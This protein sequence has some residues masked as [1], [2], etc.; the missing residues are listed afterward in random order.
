MSFEHVVVLQL[1]IVNGSF[2]LYKL[3]RA[4]P[5]ANKI[6]PISETLRSGT[7]KAMPATTKSNLSITLHSLNK[8]PVITTSRQNTPANVVITVSNI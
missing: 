2:K 6:A 3:W 8:Y 5:I 4:N 1:V 7:N